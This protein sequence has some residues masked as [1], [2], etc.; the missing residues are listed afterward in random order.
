MLFMNSFKGNTAHQ[1]KPPESQARRFRLVRY[2]TWTGLVML[3]P[4]VL[5]LTYF[6]VQQ[7][8]FFLQHTQEDKEYF[9]KMQESL[10]QQQDDAARRDRRAPQAF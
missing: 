9:K 2:F 1:P 8:N 7:G 6:L 10:A 3:V 4:V 5:T